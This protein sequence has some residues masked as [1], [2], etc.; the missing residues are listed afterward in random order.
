[1]NGPSIVLTDDDESE[2]EV[3]P[4]R[5]SAFQIPSRSPVGMAN[6][7]LINKR[8][9]SGDVISMSSGSVSSGSDSGSVASESGTEETGESEEW[10]GG[11]PNYGG[12]PAHRDDGRGGFGQ[13]ANMAERMA[14]ERARLE[15]ELNEKREILFQMD[16]LEARGYQL[17]KRFSMESNLEEMRTEYHR[18]LREKELDASI[19]FQQKMLV[20]FVTG[21]EFLNTRFD[22]FGV[23]LEGWSENVHE[24]LEDYTEIFTELHD[25]Y[26]GSGKKMAPEL[27]LMMSLSGS[28]FMYHLTN[29]MFKQR[30]LP[31]VENV[32]R[33]NPELMRQFQS[34][35]MQQMAM[36]GGM[37]PNMGGAPPPPPAPMGGMGGPGG[38]G[39][40]GIFGMMGNLFGG[41]AGG[42][43]APPSQVAPM[44]Q[45]PP[46]GGQPGGPPPPLRAMVPPPAP[47][48]MPRAPP[49]MPRA[50][51]PPPQA[52]SIHQNINLKPKGTGN[53]ETISISDEEITSIIEDAAGVL[54]DNKS[55][56]SGAGGAARRG[57]APKRTLEL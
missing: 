57:G 40:G 25:K 50:P 24:G 44:S 47:P 16:R 43:R 17:P 29:S 33:S 9:V 39:M 5:P 52:A 35:A 19:R 45:M 53:I 21:I 4:M 12:A 41:G 37:P 20:A 28:A 55:V 7:M 31:D 10:G 27:R 48:P 23:K 22:P 15:A 3:S 46:M 18:V 6:D 54:R 51:P 30:P 36:G 1:M 26:K 13:Q 42:A 32:L 14:T 49:P 56:T 11:R 38:P 8:K 34:A 2:I